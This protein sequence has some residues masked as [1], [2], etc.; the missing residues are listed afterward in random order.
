MKTLGQRCYCHYSAARS[1][2]VGAGGFRLSAAVRCIACASA[3][4]ASAGVASV[5]VAY[6]AVVAASAAVVAPL[7]AATAAAG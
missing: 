1:G 7:A 6:G 3:G 4:V 5:G 2:K